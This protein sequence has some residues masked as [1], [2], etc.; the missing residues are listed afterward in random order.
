LADSDGPSDKAPRPWAVAVLIDKDL[1]LFDPKLGVPVPA[2]IKLQEGGPLQI[3]PAT[4][5]QV[6]ADEGLLRRMDADAEHLYPVK[7]EDLKR[8][9]ALVEASPAYLSMRMKIAESR[10]AGERTMVLTCDPTAQAD[11]M[12]AVPNV[13]KVDIWTHPYETFYNRL[14]LSVDDKNRQ[15]TALMPFIP[16]VDAPLYKGR[17]LYFKGQFTGQRSATWFF[18]ASRT[19]EKKLAEM[20][21][22]QQNDYF[23]QNLPRIRLLPEQERKATLERLKAMSVVQA[24]VQKRILQWAKQDASYWLGLLNFERGKYEVAIDYLGNRTLEAVSNSS[25][26]QGAFYNLGRCY[27]AL[28]DPTRAIKVYLSDSDSDSPAALG[29]ALR[30]KWLQAEMDATK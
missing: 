28:G 4:L 12:K 7:A 14:H 11:R 20:Q 15:K 17:L 16:G 24:D 18:Q 3:E 26:T 6:V 22:S 25:W 9:V 29:N 10:L 19:S 8:V 13:N 30:A 2:G 5:A 1:Y 21:D 23:Q 27:E